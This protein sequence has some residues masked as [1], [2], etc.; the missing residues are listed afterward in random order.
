MSSEVAAKPVVRACM[1]PLA[2]IPPSPRLPRHP[3]LLRS[4]PSLRARQTHVFVKRVGALAEG[5]AYVKL[6]IDSAACEDVAD[7]VELAC[8][9]F[10][11]GAP[12]RAH[13]H[14]V[15]RPAAG[16]GA[17]SSE[18]ERRALAGDELFPAASLRSA[19]VEAGALLLARVP[20]GAGACRAVRM[21]RVGCVRARHH[22]TISH[23]ARSV[24]PSMRN[25]TR[26]PPTQRSRSRCLRLR[27]LRTR[28]ADTLLTR[29]CCPYQMSSARHL[30]TRRARR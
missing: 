18:D 2:C 20:L 29:V 22:I 11:W 13:L 12:S 14:L 30:S 16:G 27:H 4:P 10:G 7:L 5:E 25:L 19:G 9:A 24:P 8:A 28:R 21:G 15:R 1:L 17:P 26:S 6:K 23:F 3:L